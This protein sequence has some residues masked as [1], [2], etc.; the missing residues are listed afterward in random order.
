MVTKL[1]T[2]EKK[3]WVLFEHYLRF[4]SADDLNKWPKPDQIIYITHTCPTCSELPSNISTMG[5]CSPIA[6]WTY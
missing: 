6:G 4:T 2:R 5:V 1:R 3:A